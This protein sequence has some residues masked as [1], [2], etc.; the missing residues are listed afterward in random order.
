VPPVIQW[1][2]LAVGVVL[3]YVAVTSAHTP[4]LHRPFQKL[5]GDE[6][7]G[8]VLVERVR[9]GNLEELRSQYEQQI[10]QAARLEERARLARDL[11]DAVKQQLFAIQTSAATA[12]ER[13]PTDAAGATSALEQVRES[14]RHA[15]TEMKALI[16]QLQSSP[17]ENTG[18]ITSL[19]EQ[20]DALAL[21]T[22]AE[23]TFDT[24]TLPPSHALPPGTQQALFRAAQEALSNI[25]RHA[26]ATK[27]SVRLA[28]TGDRL[29]LAIRDNGAGFDPHQLKPGMGLK[30]MGARVA[31]VSG[32]MLFAPQPGGGTVV[33][34]SVP[35]DVNT[36]G[37]YARRAWIWLAVVAVMLVDISAGPGWDRPFNAIIAAIA[38]VTVARYVAAWWR[39]RRLPQAAAA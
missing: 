34:F 33:A 14:A 31:G 24:G 23:V 13:M 6:I 32:T 16:E 29:E 25:A 4:R 26:R 39:T 36:A 17:L 37:D 20:C 2:P 15:M 3:M 18:L 11:H 9:G 28:L 5:V 30:N 19:R 27:V 35:C 12:Q 10:R 8:P 7:Q 1:T 21:R 38:S 22:G